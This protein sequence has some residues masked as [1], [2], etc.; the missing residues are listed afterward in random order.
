MCHANEKKAMGD[1]A[2]LRLEEAE[3]KRAKETGK[4]ILCNPCQ[5]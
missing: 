1:G 5:T 4:R 2:L 3:K